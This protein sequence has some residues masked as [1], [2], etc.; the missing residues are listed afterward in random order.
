[1]EEIRKQGR[2]IVDAPEQN[3]L[4]LYRDTRVDYPAKAVYLVGT[5]LGGMIDMGNHP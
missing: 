1:M 4:R 3:R 2:G 5:Q